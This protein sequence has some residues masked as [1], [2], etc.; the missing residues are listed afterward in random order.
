M[1]RD[2]GSVWYFPHTGAEWFTGDRFESLA[3][4]LTSFLSYFVFGTGYGA[5]VGRDRWYEFLDRDGL[6]QPFEPQ[7]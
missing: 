4:D 1:E 6:L 3:Q 2:T 5:L 7:P